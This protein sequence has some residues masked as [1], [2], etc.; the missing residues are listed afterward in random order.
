[1][2]LF[3]TLTNMTQ[4]TIDSQPKSLYGTVTRYYDG[5]CTVKTD[6]GI[7]ENIQCVNVY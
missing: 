2:G 7:L 6:D 4:D 5:A 3:D 1:M